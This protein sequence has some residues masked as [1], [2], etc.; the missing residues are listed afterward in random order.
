MSNSLIKFRFAGVGAVILLVQ[1]L[2]AVGALAWPSAAPAATWTRCSGENGRCEM[3]DM[4]HHL[5]RYGADGKFNFVETDGT[6]FIDCN[7]G[8]FGD[9]ASGKGKVCDY[10]AAPAPKV[11]WVVCASETLTCRLPDN[12]PRLVKY[13]GGAAAVLKIAST[14]TACDN[15]HFGDI[16]PGMGKSCAY[17]ST[18]YSGM[19]GTGTFASLCAEYQDCSL[20]GNGGVDPILVRFGAGTGWIYETT[21]MDSFK[22]N[23][24]TFSNDPAYGVGKFCQYVAITPTVQGVNGYW[25][26]VASCANCTGLTKK[27]TASVTG[28]RATTNS[29]M[30]SETVSI[31]YKKSFGVPGNMNEVSVSASQTYARTESVTDSLSRTSSE[32]VDA[33]CPGG[34]SVSMWQWTIDVS[35]LCWAQGGSCKTSVT[36]LNILC[37]SSPPT[38][39]HPQC[40][41]GTFTDP[42]AM[43]CP[44]APAQTRRRETPEEAVKAWG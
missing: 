38:N 29:N 19:A 7:N 27:V 39:F 15:Q 26:Q 40:A 4:A 25:R 24:D 44:V 10:I 36:T 18:P 3:S 11:T 41:P 31:G 30:W 16:A 42:F 12:A 32:E 9:P 5:V 28:A 21:T 23:S 35:D 13:M 20:Q 34:A 37:A 17:A 2:L 6:S 22:C 8:V 43:S 33:N 1:A 14:S